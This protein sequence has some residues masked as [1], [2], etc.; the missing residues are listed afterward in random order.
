MFST[1]FPHAFGLDIGDLSIK[2][3]QI[4]NISFR[5]YS[6]RFKLNSFCSVALPPGLIVNG[7]IQKP[8]EVRDHIRILLKNKKNRRKPIKGDWVVASL[9]ESQCYIKHLTIQKSIEEISNDDVLHAAEKHIPFDE[10]SY[11]IDW[12]IVPNND[13]NDNNTAVI[14]G[15]VPKNIVNNYTYLI[16]SM[17][18]GVVALEIEA[19]SIVRSMITA[20]KQYVGEARAILDLGATKTHLIIHDNNSLQFSVSLPFSGE[21]ID[22]TLSQKMEISREE[23]EKRK[24]L[25]GLDY[26]TNKSASF[27][28]LVGLVDDLAESI[29]KA[30]NFYYSHFPKSN[31]I[32]RIVMCGGGA[33]LLQLDRVLSLKLKIAT[34]P[35]Q[36]W[37]N[38]MGKKSTESD[39]KIGLY[40]AT[41]IGLAL[42]A[43]D[44]PFF[45][46]TL[47]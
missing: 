46:K 1:P 20:S 37:K 11:Y 43:A 8:E 15:A 25:Y 18:L 38:L 14:I 30:L 29:E 19:V 12:Q 36:P 6:P 21:M 5:H 27:P 4:R 33:N 44:N 7:E 16:E 23:A 26:P 32:T 24:I 2:A 40:Y 34:H 13:L 41:A 45:T 22:N 10:D 17:G 3:V 47:I 31:K 9:P 28:I 39:G 42:R 35:G